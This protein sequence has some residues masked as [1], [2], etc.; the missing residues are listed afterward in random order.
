MKIALIISFF[1]LSL[2]GSGQTTGPMTC[3][4]MMTKLDASVVNSNA[5]A[6]TIADITGLAFHVLAGERYRFKFF[7]VYSAAAPTTGAR[8]S[9][10]GPSIT[11]LAYNSIY[12]LTTTSQTVNTGLNA[13]NLP[14]A[15][16]LSSAATSGNIAIVEGII[17]PSQAGIV[18]GRF[19]SEVS[20][21][22]ITIV[23]GL[24]YVTYQKLN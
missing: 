8:F 9:I 24:S 1:L 5:S 22:A 20:N 13:Y 18:I 2:S 7:I 19:A 12:T 6:N 3:S 10:N 4:D 15:S 17:Q 14:A 21:S 16:N 23:A 11:N